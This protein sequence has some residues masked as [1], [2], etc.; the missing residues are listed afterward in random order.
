MSTGARFGAAPP[1]PPPPPSP[2]QGETD[3]RL[4]WTATGSRP[5]VFRAPV[6]PSLLTSNSISHLPLTSRIRRANHRRGPASTAPYSRAGNAAVP[7]QLTSQDCTRVTVACLP[8]GFST[9]AAA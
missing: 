7:M 3:C 6:G 5:P 8:L 9:R 2:G 4:P 1:G